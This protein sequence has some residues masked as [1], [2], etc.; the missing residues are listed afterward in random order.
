MWIHLYLCKNPGSF[1]LLFLLYLI[2]SA[3]LFRRRKYSV[4]S[5]SSIF[6]YSIFVSYFSLIFFIII[7]H[8]VFFFF[9][10]FLCKIV[11][12]FCYFHNKTHHSFDF[13]IFLKV[14]IST[15]SSNYKFQKYT[16]YF[17]NHR[18]FRTKSIHP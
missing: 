4:S 6:P 12:L 15:F 5:F 2:F 10:S 14:L 16:W 8:K 18:I 7:F 1:F 9:A 11:F 3:S 17:Y 13:T